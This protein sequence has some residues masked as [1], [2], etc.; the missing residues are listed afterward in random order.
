MCGTAFQAVAAVFRGDPNTGC[1]REPGGHRNLLDLKNA[2]LLLFWL[3]YQPTC[4]ITGTTAWK[5]VP[6][7]SCG[8]GIPRRCQCWLSARM[9]RAL[10]F[11]V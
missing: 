11:A 6:L 1:Q 10:Q 4:R 3:E 8:R 2:A 7:S 9:G 5:A